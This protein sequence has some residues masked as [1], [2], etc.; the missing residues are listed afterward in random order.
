MTERTL[1]FNVIARAE[2][3]GSPSTTSPR[4]QRSPPVSA[5]GEWPARRSCAPRG[6]RDPSCT[7]QRRAVRPRIS[8]TFLRATARFG[9]TFQSVGIVGLVR[10]QGFNLIVAGVGGPHSARLL[11]GRLAAAPGPRS[12]RVLW[13]VAFRPWLGWRDRIRPGAHPRARPAHRRGGD[14]RESS[15]CSPELRRRSSRRSSR[16]LARQHRDPSVGRPRRAHPRPRSRLRDGY[17]SAIKQVGTVLRG[18]GLQAA[19]LFATGVPLLDRFGTIGLGI[20][21]L[22]GSVANARCSGAPS[23]VT[24][25]STSSRPC[26]PRRGRVQSPPARICPRNGGGPARLRWRCPRSLPRDLLALS[27]LPLPRRAAVHRPPGQAESSCR[28]DACRGNLPPDRVTAPRVAA[29][30]RRRPAT[31][32]SDCCTLE[33]ERRGVRFVD[34]PALKAGWFATAQATR[35][36]PPALARV[37]LQ[38]RRPA[39]AA[40]RACAQAGARPDPR[41]AGTARTRDPRRLDRPQPAPA[42][43]TSRGWHMP[44][45][46]PDPRQRCPHRALRARPFAPVRDVAARG[47]DRRP[48]ASQLH[49][50]LPGRAAVARAGARAAGRAARRVRVP[51][52]RPDPPYKRVPRWSLPS[53]GSMRPTLASW[54]PGTSPDAMPP[55]VEQARAA[56]PTRKSSLRSGARRRRGSMHGAAVISLNHEA[57]VGR[58]EPRKAATTSGTRL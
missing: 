45:S 7:R 25:A 22:A 39:A 34:A 5:S 44:R 50:R 28:R 42:R 36:R 2:V 1:A 12:V 30:P 37:P 53:A 14:R 6:V 54:S 19:V 52:L 27:S 33:L 20:S 4:S 51:G 10:D 46:P 8:R 35:R 38:R 29:F 9:L 47:P 11:D 43:A 57:S 32:T 18:A 13:R 56:D 21:W 49:R 41:A 48:S 17:L 31:P 26:E 40:R 16:A 23:A 58:I 3:G 55:A 24:R 15:S